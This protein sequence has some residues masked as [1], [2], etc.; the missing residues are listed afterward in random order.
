MIQIQ[1]KSVYF[2]LIDKMNNFKTYKYNAKLNYSK[3]NAVLA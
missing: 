2:K 3:I 1:I